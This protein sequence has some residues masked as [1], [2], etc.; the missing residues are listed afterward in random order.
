LPHEGDFVGG[1]AVGFV[2]EVADLAFEA[3]GIGGKCAGRMYLARVPNGGGSVGERTVKAC[4]GILES[5]RW[6][7]PSALG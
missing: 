6:Y 1:E 5:G 7:W 4:S 2:D 3:E